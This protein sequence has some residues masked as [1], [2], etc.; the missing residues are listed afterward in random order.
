MVGLLAALKQ[1]GQVAVLLER[2]LKVLLEL[3]EV[4]ILL[5][6]AAVVG[7]I[8]QRLV[9]EVLVVLPLVAL[10]A[11]LLAT[12]LPLALAVLVV[13]ALFASTLGKELT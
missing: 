2:L 6:A 5:V 8:L 11:E 7:V 12:V 1:V 4:L 9:L 13:L 10:V 3:R